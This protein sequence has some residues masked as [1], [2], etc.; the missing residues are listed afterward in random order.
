[1]TLALGAGR[2]RE[3]GESPDAIVQFGIEVPIPLFDRNQGRRAEAVVLHRK[4]QVGQEAVAIDLRSRLTAA[5]RE[6]E[7]ER[8]KLVAAGERL[9][10]PAQRAV[11]H[12]STL[13]AEGKVLN[14]DVLDAQRVLASAQKTLLAAR[15]GMALAIAG[16]VS[17][18]GEER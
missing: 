8:A 6:V 12:A 15:H 13:Y 1:M 5:Y 4:S 7:R 14:L 17:L 9:V 16:L 2:S 3:P 11:Q 10:P 18:T